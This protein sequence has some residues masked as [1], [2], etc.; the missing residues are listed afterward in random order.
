VR[1]EASWLLSGA[2]RSGK[3]S[4]HSRRRSRFGG[5]VEAPSSLP[6]CYGPQPLLSTARRPLSVVELLLDGMLAI[7]PVY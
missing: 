2:A 4:H 7:V 6:R 1:R 5:R 3:Y